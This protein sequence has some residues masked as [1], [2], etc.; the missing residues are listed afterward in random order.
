VTRLYYE[1]ELEGGEVRTL[2][3]DPLEDRWYEQ[4]VE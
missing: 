4:R 3:H 2:F 1:L